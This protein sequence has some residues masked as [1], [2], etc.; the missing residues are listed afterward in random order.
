MVC[1]KNGHD[2]RRMRFWL[3]IA[4]VVL[5]C[6]IFV[7]CFSIFYLKRDDFLTM[8]DDYIGVGS[9]SQVPRYIFYGVLINTGIWCAV[10]V[11][12]MFMKNRGLNML[13]IMGGFFLVI[14]FLGME[15]YIVSRPEIQVAGILG[16]YEMRTACALYAE[17][18]GILWY[19]CLGVNLLIA[20]C[21][22]VVEGDWEMLI[23]N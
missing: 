5:W 11:L 7:I 23:L 17:N 16:I 2:A 22:W 14:M 15:W 4:S 18:V 13:A 6:V 19:V 8:Y 9:V 20:L 12:S 3:S 1:E 21:R 10:G